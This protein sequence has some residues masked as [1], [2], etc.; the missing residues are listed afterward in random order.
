[1]NTTCAPGSKVTGATYSVA[2]PPRLA[3]PSSSGT[4]SA[5][6]LH[7]YVKPPSV[8]QANPFSL[9]GSTTAPYTVTAAP[10]RKRLPA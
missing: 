3:G 1:M 7:A 4:S 6:T 2:V 5:L 8:L 9:V 10:R